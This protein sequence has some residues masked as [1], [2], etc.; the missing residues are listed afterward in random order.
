MQTELRSLLILYDVLKVD[1]G[2]D[3]LGGRGRW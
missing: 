3:C 2:G 1:I